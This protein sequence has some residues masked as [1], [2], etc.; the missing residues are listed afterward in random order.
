MKNIAWP[1]TKLK[2]FIEGALSA[3]NAAGLTRG[4]LYIKKHT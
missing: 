2:I 3:K 1:K 4:P